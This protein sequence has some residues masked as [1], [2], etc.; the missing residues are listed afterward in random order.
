MIVKHGCQEVKGLAAT[1]KNLV[2]APE[3]FSDNRPADN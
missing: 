1:S 3:N 2:R